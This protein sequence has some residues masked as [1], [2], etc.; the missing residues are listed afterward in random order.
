MEIKAR[1]MNVIIKKMVLF[2]SVGFSY[3]GK[4]QIGQNPRKRQ[5]Y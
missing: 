3:L 1:T 5:Y 4:K 2:I